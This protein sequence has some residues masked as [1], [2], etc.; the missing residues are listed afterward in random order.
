MNPSLR[1]RN[2]GALALLL[3]GTTQM[4]GYL[5]GLLPLRGLGLA[6]GMAPFPKVFCEVDGYEPFAATFTLLGD[7][8]DGAPQAIAINAE[9]YS[10]LAGPYL[11]RNVYG[12]ALAYAPRLPDELRDHLLQ[13]ILLP[14]SPLP[15]ELTLPD[16]QNP[17]ILIDARDGEDPPTYE[18]N[19][20]N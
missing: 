13:H 18:F 11:R 14:G 20:T 1:I 9:R 7:D 16:L 17:R 3:L 5:S 12:A 8:A 15:T 2:L 19:L 10:R 4:L 6:S